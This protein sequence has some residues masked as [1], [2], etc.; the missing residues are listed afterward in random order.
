MR[1]I[2]LAIALIGLAGPAIAQ[3]RVVTGQFGIL[4]EWDMAATVAEQAAGG[5]A[6]PLTLRHTGFC[7][8]DGPEEKTGE[9]RLRLTEPKGRVMATVLIDG[10]TC[11]FS[12]PLTD[13]YEG[14]MRC[15]DR[16]DVP[17]ALSVE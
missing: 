4:G 1:P 14:V 5:W 8:I 3:T 12:A 2:C 15:P 6:G 13:G 11:S 10:M 9:I 7:G 16:R 17:M